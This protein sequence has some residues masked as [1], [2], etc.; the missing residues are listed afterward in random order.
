MSI[1]GLGTDIIE[2]ARIKDSLDSHGETFLEKLFTEKERE[3]FQKHKNPLPII[4]GRFAAKEAIAKALGSGFGK[5]LK[6]IDIEIINNEQG[7]PE[8]SLK[9][10]ENVLISISHCKTYATAVAIWID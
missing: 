1:K 8:A 7:K 2:I 9:S 4:S 5:D 6:W 10:D 3:Y